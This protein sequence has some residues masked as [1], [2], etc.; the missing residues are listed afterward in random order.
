MKVEL[1]L[2]ASLA[3]FVPRSGPLEV[4][5]NTTILALLNAQDTSCLPVV[6]VDGEVVATKRYPSR[7]ELTALVDLPAGA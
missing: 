1:N 5:E 6:I 2:Y 7:E 4:G 3:R